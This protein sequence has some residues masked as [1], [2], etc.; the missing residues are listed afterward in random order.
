M[1]EAE[2]ENKQQL[3]AETMKKQNEDFEKKVKI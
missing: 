1:R 3:N 2:R